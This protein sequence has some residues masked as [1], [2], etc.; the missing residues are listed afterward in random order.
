MVE[1]KEP[2]SEEGQNKIKKLV[3]RDLT[4]V[5][6]NVDRQLKKCQEQ[7]GCSGGCDRY[8]NTNNHLKLLF[9]IRPFGISQY[10]KTIG[11]DDPKNCCFGKLFRKFDTKLRL[12]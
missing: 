7:P 9:S 2:E 11:V 4:G 3:Q 12:Y 6:S 5:R 1:V 10:Y 8:G